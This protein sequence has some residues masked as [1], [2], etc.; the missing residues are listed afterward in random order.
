MKGI[1]YFPHFYDLLYFFAS[2]IFP[3]LHLA[4]HVE[5][6]LLSRNDANEALESAFRENAGLSI[7]TGGM[8]RLLQASCGHPYLLQLLGYYLIT[9]ANEYSGGESYLIKPDEAEKITNMAQS[10]YEERALR[11]LLDELSPKEREYLAALARSLDDKREARTA[12]VAMRLGREPGKVGYLRE[13]LI[14]NGIVIASTHGKL[15][16]NI[17][18]LADYVLK[19]GGVNKN[20]QRLREWRV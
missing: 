17:P 4:R 13:S 19:D 20:L 7:G 10:A 2:S 8:Q 3:Y 6:S 1:L 18:Y 12:E 9:L 5:L 16:F 11:P 15:M 14:R